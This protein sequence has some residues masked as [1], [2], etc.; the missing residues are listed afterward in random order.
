MIAD[1][2]VSHSQTEPEVTT[3]DATSYGNLGSNSSS[4]TARALRDFYPTIEPARGESLASKADM[5]RVT[6]VFHASFSLC[7]LDFVGASR[8][9]HSCI[10]VCRSIYQRRVCAAG[11]AG[12]RTACL[13]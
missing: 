10:F 5:K 8:L 11:F 2:S 3:T 7:A 6:E 9:P 4:L 12:V 1:A 13:P